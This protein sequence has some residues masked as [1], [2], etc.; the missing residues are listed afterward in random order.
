[1]FKLPA[2]D[3]PKPVSDYA[4][5]LRAML[6][7]LELPNPSISM[8]CVCKRYI[9]STPLPNTPHPALP[10][11]GNVIYPQIFAWRNQ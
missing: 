5:V 9:A 10:V 3:S 4:A 2:A 11:E 6:N 8:L 1:M 7:E